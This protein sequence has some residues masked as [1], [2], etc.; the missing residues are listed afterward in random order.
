M[1]EEATD[2]ELLDLV[3][4]QLY[5]S[6]DDPIPLDVHSACAVGNYKC[7]QEWIDAGAEL[8]VKNRG[9]AHTGWGG[10]EEG[11]KG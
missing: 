9:L 3:A 5:D 6:G 7:V 10:G 4:S 8:D 2:G 11:G 1:A